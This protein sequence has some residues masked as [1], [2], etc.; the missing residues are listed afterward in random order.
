MVVFIKPIVYK[1]SLQPIQS[2]FYTT[3]SFAFFHFS[4]RNEDTMDVI[5]RFTPD[6]ICV[7][8]AILL[9]SILWVNSLCRR[10]KYRNS[11]ALPILALSFV[12]KAQIN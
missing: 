5:E 11:T 3:F 7:L 4:A 9:L 6:V 8:W 12:K 10:A 2:F 1:N